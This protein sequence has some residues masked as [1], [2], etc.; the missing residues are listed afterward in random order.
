MVLKQKLLS[1]QLLDNT[2]Y[3]CVVT[4]KAKLIAGYIGG[5]QAEI[6]IDI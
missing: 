4:Y 5:S 3:N 6:A 1:T 2:K